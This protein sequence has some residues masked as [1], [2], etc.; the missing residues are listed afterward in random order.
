MTRIANASKILIIL[1]AIFAILAIYGL[2]LTFSGDLNSIPIFIIG[3]V[4]AFICGSISGVL[5]RIARE[6]KQ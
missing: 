5:S 2:V 3:F 4:L 1:A 6:T